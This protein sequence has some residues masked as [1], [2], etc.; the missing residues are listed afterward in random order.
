MPVTIVA[1]PGAANANSYA[2]LQ[3]FKDYLALRLQTPDT[4]TDADDDTL[5]KGLIAG[6]RAIDQLLTRAKRLEV[7]K[8]SN[9]MVKF[10]TIRPYWTGSPT[11]STQ[12]L[13]WPRTGMLDRNGNPIADNVIPDDL[14]EATFEMAIVSITS[15]INAENSVI[16]QGITDIKAG[17]VSL[18]FK[19]YIQ[20]RTLPQSVV[21]AL[22]PSW[23]TEE[24]YE[25]VPQG[26]FRTVGTRC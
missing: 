24:T 2:T 3:E 6:T 19:D 22:V 4:V 15:D 23:M 21:L 17:P 13:A 10:Y 20:S 12:A 18:S 26:Q 25:N 8:S 14:K 9:N 11:T 7:I 16:V 5:S 1:T